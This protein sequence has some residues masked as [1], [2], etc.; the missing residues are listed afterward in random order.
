[1]KSVFK[2]TITATSQGLIIAYHSKS[3]IRDYIFT[4][5]EMQS[6]RKCRFIMYNNYVTI[7]NRK[8]TVTFNYC[9]FLIKKKENIFSLQ[10]V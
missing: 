8:M 10:P 1:M 3:L 5:F 7:I 4:L 2:A 6:L 9:I